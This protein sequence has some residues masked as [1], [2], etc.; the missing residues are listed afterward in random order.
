[1]IKYH[2][3]Q[4]SNGLKIIVHRDINTPLVAFNLLYDVGSRDE[5]PEKT[6]FAH[7]FEHLMF[8]GSSNVPKFDKPI[9]EAAGS[10]NAFTS[11]DITNYYITLPAVNVE[12]A[13]WVESDRMKNLLI[14]EKSLETQKKVVSEE[15]RQ[16]YLN[17]PYGDA[18]LLLHDLAYKTH[19]YRW[20]PIGIDLS[21]IQNANL[22]DVQGFFSKHYRPNRAILSIAG[23]VDPDEMLRLAEKWFGDIEPNYDYHRNLS[24]EPVQDTYRFLEVKRNV[25]TDAIYK[26]F[27]MGKRM[28]DDYY[29]S[30]ILS[31]ILANG[32]S[33]R[34]YRNLYKKKGLFV[35]ISSSISGSIDEGLL[36][37]VGKIA[38][39][40]DPKQA[41]DAINE[42]LK[43]L[44]HEG[45]KSTELEKV[46]NKTISVM[47]FS[48]MNILNKAM[49]LAYFECLGKIDLINNEIDRYRKIEI[50]D[51]LRVGNQMFTN[52]NLSDL[53]YLSKKSNMSPLV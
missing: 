24:K 7:L 52:N 11:R 17:Q 19:P 1:M 21:H 8:E 53:F 38:E 50:E 37:I 41:N 46:I 20:N 15:F 3:T 45:I 36:Y 9:Q 43:L 51:L 49:N 4:L 16:S 5:N 33:S 10:N 13:F 12:T 30:D 28:E 25:P 23:N 35:E 18:M 34:L 31:D 2:K 29:V 40:I 47:M 44:I 6:G 42:E 26:A 48:K 39:G 32:T 22:E 14:S 27:H